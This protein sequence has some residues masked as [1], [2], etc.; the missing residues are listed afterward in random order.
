MD[1]ARHHVS[2]F[3]HDRD[4]SRDDLGA[5][6]VA[7][8][9]ASVATVKN[10]TGFGQLVCSTDHPMPEPVLGRRRDNGGA[11][12]RPVRDAPPKISHVAAVHLAGHIERA[13]LHPPPHVARV[14]RARDGGLAAPRVKPPLAQVPRLA[15]YL[16]GTRGHGLN[17]FQA[18]LA[19]DA[20]PVG[21]DLAVSA[22]HARP[23]IGHLE[24]LYTSIVT[25][26]IVEE[27]LDELLAKVKN[28][29][30]P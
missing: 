26:R 29:A 17:L 10:D 7:V 14:V 12:V 15:A 6:A 8:P 18:Q 5:H 9:D 28:Q 13:V 20:D 16:K 3:V 27:R 4:G 24:P 22:D 30:G 25:K 11:A 2:I 19:I 21:H 1:V 23:H